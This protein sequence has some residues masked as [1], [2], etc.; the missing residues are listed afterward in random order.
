MPVRTQE[1]IIQEMDVTH[2]AYFNCL[3]DHSLTMLTL[4][5]MRQLEAELIAVLRD[6]YAAYHLEHL[7]YM[8]AWYNFR[9]A[10]GI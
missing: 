5:R 1:E 10:K 8:T 4:V 3:L 6:K 7:S 9:Q 2:A